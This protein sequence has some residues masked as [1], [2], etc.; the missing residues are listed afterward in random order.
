[1]KYNDSF[2]QANILDFVNSLVAFASVFFDSGN[3]LLSEFTFG[4]RA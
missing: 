4:V 3:R 2:N 1:M